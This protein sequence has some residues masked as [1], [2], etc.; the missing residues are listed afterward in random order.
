MNF[1]SLCPHHKEPT[2]LFCEICEQTGCESC[3]LYGPHNNQMH[4]V[5]RLDEAFQ[6]R[7]SYLNELVCGGLLEKRDRLSKYLEELTLLGD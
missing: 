3:L 5:S 2:T 4:R 1:L 7:Y 6:A